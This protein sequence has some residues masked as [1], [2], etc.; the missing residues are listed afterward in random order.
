M[1]RPSSL[2]SGAE[3]GSYQGMPS[4]MPLIC[5]VHT[6]LE[7]LSSRAP[8]AKAT[9]DANTPIAALKALRRP[10]TAQSRRRRFALAFVVAAAE[11]VNE[12]LFNRLVVGDEHVADGVATDEVADFLGEVFGVIASPLQR[13]GHED[14]LQAGLAMHVFRVLNVAQEDQVAQAIHFGVGA[15]NVDGLAD[16]AGGK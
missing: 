14:D 15:E 5:T 11:V 12:H 3:E 13:L 6:R 8:A 10:K 7:P 9:S 4:G 16:F 1:I 2:G